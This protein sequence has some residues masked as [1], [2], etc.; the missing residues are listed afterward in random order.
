[1]IHQPLGWA[2]WQ[3]TDIIIQAEHIKMLKNKLNKLLAKHTWQKLSQIEKD[4]ERD[5]WMS[6]QDAADYWIVD[7]LIWN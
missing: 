1:M 4:V 3:A 5:Y 7:K 6:A 2:E